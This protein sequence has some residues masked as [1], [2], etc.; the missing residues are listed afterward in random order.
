MQPEIKY[1]PVNWVDGMKISEAHF[2][3]LQS[4]TIDN[5]RDAIAFGITNY[6]Y[7]LLQ[8]APGE[9]TSLDIAI[10]FDQSKLIRV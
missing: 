7:G 8:P 2:N 10:G 5:V 3:H 4:F 9:K 1:F 6:N